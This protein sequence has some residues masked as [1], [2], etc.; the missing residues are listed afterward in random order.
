MVWR[1]RRLT[2]RATFVD[3]QDKDMSRI[4]VAFRAFFR[5]L[6]N[7]EFAEQVGCLLE[8]APLPER[9]APALPP[10]SGSPSAPPSAAEKR[11]APRKTGR[12]DALNLLAALQREARLVDFIK[13]P[14]A[15]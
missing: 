6:R 14:L 4:G 12:N 15:E 8:G 3:R 2:V 13:E 10:P 7:A 1:V 5:S 11:P 9:G